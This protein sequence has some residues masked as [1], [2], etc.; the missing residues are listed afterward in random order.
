MEDTTMFVAARDLRAVAG[1]PVAAASPA[2]AAARARRR[3]AAAA[4]CASVREAG[5]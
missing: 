5:F 4:H 3:H 1:A 2:A